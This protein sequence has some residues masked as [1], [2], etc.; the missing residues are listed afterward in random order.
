MA[1]F[2]IVDRADLLP[3]DLP[4]TR[5]EQLDVALIEFE[6]IG[7]PPRGELIRSI[8]AIGVQ[9]PITVEQI[10]APTDQYLYNLIAGRRRQRVA[11]DLGFETIPAL[12]YPSG[13]SKTMLLTDHAQRHANPAAELRA[14]E[15]LQEQGYT[16]KEIAYATGMTIG[17]I[18]NRV[19]LVGLCAELRHAF[20]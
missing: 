14:I 4:D 10:E 6:D 16:E 19:K 15:Q 1:D 12:I 5:L 8:R 3:T 7:P 13:F 18:R 9:T 17:T 20:D 11:L 2:E